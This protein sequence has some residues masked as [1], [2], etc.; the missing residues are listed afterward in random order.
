MKDNSTIVNATITGIGLTWGDGTSG[1]ITGQ[2][3]VANHLYTAN[4]TYNVLEVVTWTNL[5]TKT[6][7]TTSSNESVQIT[8]KGSG[9]G[10]GCTAGCSSGPPPPSSTTF[11]FN[12]FTALLMGLGLS[13]LIL[14][15]VPGPVGARLGIGVVVT[16][17]FSIL[18]LVVGG[19]GIL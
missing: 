5:I 7:A 9:G 11:L 18:G 6:T 15:W 2:F 3:G 13:L 14:P 17:V 4:G 12:A 16:L 8:V 1:T 19:P 10:G